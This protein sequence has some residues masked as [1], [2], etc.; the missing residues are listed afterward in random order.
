MDKTKRAAIASK[1]GVAAHQQGRAH[2][3]SSEEAR[4]AGKIGGKH[5]W[6]PRKSTD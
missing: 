2:T 4:R 5:R 6:P 3:F 1:G